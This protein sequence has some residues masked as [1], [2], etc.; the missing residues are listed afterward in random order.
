MN[1]PSLSNAGPWTIGKEVAE[2]HAPI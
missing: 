2:E 1:K